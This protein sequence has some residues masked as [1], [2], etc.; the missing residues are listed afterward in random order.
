MKLTRIGEI[1]VNFLRVNSITL[2]SCN[3]YYL[4]NLY[5]GWQTPNLHIQGRA[6]VG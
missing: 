2:I 5:N 1:R 3:L 4:A 6:G